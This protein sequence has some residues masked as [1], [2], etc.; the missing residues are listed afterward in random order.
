MIKVDWLAA[1]VLQREVGAGLG[2]VPVSWRIICKILL[3]HEKQDMV[4]DE[5]FHTLL[6]NEN[7]DKLKD[8]CE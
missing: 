2:M 5:I 8:T 4:A 7:Q 3:A 1:D 6:T